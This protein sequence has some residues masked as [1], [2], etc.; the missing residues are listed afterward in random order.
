MFF[1]IPRQDAKDAKFLY[2]LRSW[3]LCEEIEN[4]NLWPREVYC[5]KRLCRMA[6]LLVVTMALRQSARLR[7]TMPACSA[8]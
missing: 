6:I 2:S 4:I 8:P 3:R 5:I 7:L 1:L